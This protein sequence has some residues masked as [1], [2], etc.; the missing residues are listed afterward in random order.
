MLHPVRQYLSCLNPASNRFTVN[1]GFVYGPY[2]KILPAPGSE[3]ELGSNIFNW[4]LLNGSFPPAGMAPP[5]VVDVRDIA[6]AHVAAIKLP[7]FSPANTKRF[8]VNGSNFEWSEA[9]EAVRKAVPEITTLPAASAYGGIPGPAAIL[10]SSRA[11]RELGLDK[12]IPPAQT[13]IDT[14]KDLNRLRSEWSAPKV[15]LVTGITGFIAGHVT[16]RLIEQGYRV[17]GSVLIFDSRSSPVNLYPIEP[18]ARPSTIN[19]PNR[20]FPD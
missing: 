10:D 3:A 19:S 16:E 5:W 20:T 2:A 4:M 6:K 7:A 15:V 8:L 18:S 9:A 17:R 14:L 11:K 12:F 13:F 1:P